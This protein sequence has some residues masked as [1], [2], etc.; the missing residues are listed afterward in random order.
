MHSKEPQVLLYIS[1]ACHFSPNNFFIWMIFLQLV[2]KMVKI[3][4]VT[5]KTHHSLDLREATTFPLIVY[6]VPGH[7]TN[8]QMSFCPKTPKLESWNFQNWDSRNF[9]NPYLCVQTFNWDEIWNKVVTLIE[10]FPTVCGTPL[11]H[12]GI[13]VIPNF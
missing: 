8:T 6:F 7:G 10:I 1:F 5:H 11:A 3:V 4:L 13:K 12:K 9:G 2:M